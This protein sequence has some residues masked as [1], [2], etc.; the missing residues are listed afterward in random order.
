MIRMTAVQVR[1][2]PALNFGPPRTPL[3]TA[4]LGLEG[5]QR[6][7][8]L[9]PDGKRF[10]M[11]RNL[12]PPPDVPALVLIQTGSGSCVQQCDSARRPDQ[13]TGVRAHASTGAGDPAGPAKAGHHDPGRA[14]PS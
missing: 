7:F 8:D 6:T 14:P 5:Q 12:P 4:S 13:R 9:S 2:G 1:T 10:L 11:V 3:D